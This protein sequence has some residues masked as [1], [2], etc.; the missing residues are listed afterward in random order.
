MNF[1]EVSPVG[2]VGQDFAVLTYA[3]REELARGQ[4]V[5][6]PVGAR[7]FVG[8]VMRAASKPSF[9]CKEILRV[10]FDAP[11][12]P[13][14][15]A[16]H[17]WLSDFYTTHGSVVWQTMLPSGLNKNRRAIAAKSPAAKNNSGDTRTNFVLNDDQTRAVREL[18]AMTSGTA[19]L[20]G[21][22][23]SGKTAVYIE[24]TRRAAANGRSAIVLVPEIALTAQLVQAFERE[25]PNQILLTH[26]QQTESQRAKTW[27]DSL[28]STVPKIAIGPRSALFS[29]LKNLGLI[30]IDECHEPSYKQEKAP[31]YSALR[32][33]AKLAETAGAKLVLGS[34][35]PLIA[36]VYAAKQ[37]GRP[38]VEMTKLARPDAVKPV[39]KI[40]DLTKRDNFTSESRVFSRPLLAA[41][42]TALADKKQILLFHNRRGSATTTLC[43][44]CGWLATCPRCFLPLTLHA[45]QFA[46]RCH[47]CNFTEKPPSKCPDCGSADILHRGLGTKKIEEECRRLFPAATLGRFDGDNKKGETTAELFTELQAGG[48]DIII[49]TQ[50]IAKGLDLPKLA[51]VG[52]PQADAGLNLP[53]FGAAE[54]TFQLIAQA[55]GRVGRTAAPTKVIIQTFQPDAPAVRYG[56]TQNYD[57]FYKMEI[58]RRQRGHFPPFAYL[59]KLTCQYKT[60]KGAVHAA[61]KLAAGIRAQ[62]GEK[63]KILGPAPAFYERARDKFRWQIVVRASSRNVLN[64]IAKKIPAK[65]WTAE[66]D[67]NSLI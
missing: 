39:T 20:H 67:P 21:V 65:N 14:L 34:A 52:I 43:E 6:I 44:N 60:E 49:G 9:A 25:F 5:E 37:L 57:E 1:Y 66:L 46:L 22:T 38:I 36:D 62:F 58:A 61:Q 63:V 11:L 33:A 23:G 3:F 50:Q 51:L 24:L 35:T 27:L 26:S 30:V 7:R 10:L 45:D 54:R 18:S 28:T 56:A 29:P 31:R 16:L 47:L 53:D 13:A 15:M 48:I 41:M 2:I 32:A 19:I 55:C 12:P 40:V 17:A 8:V 64:D 42:K 59:L 4:I